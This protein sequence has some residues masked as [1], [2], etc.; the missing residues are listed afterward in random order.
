MEQAAQATA[1]F[2][3]RAFV[4]AAFT[5]RVYYVWSLLYR[6]VFEHHYRTRPPI[7]TFPDM[8]TLSLTLARMRWRKDGPQE[9]GDAIG[10]AR[11][12]YYRHVEG[13]AVGDCDEFAVLAADR[14]EDMRRHGCEAG[15]EL[16]E[17]EIGVLSV[18]WLDGWR[19]GGHNVCA[20]SYYDDERLERRWAHVGNWFAGAPRWKFETL[21]AAVRDVLGPTR[22]GLCWSY[23]TAGLRRLRFGWRA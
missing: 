19:A 3:C 9:M 22:R 11:A 21:E 5:L 23:A 10:S 18:P 6:A 7:P 13:H 8:R 12:A 20:F 15:L 2:V 4:Y 16:R 14:M 1:A 17:D